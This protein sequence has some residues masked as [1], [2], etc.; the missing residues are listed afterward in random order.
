MAN[1]GTGLKQLWAGLLRSC[2]VLH[3]LINHM[4]VEAFHSF[5]RF[6]F[7]WYETKAQISS[8]RPM[9]TCSTQCQRSPSAPALVNYKKTIQY[10]T[11]Q[12]PLFLTF[13]SAVKTYEIRREESHIENR[14][15]T[16]WANIYWKLYIYFWPGMVMIIFIWFCFSIFCPGITLALTV[17]RYIAVCRPHQYRNIAS[18]S[19]IYTMLRK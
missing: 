4:R 16:L 17:E 9:F 19:M 7:I 18:V 1:S 6:L 12:L 2:N 5:Y 13:K 15:P 8:C 3:W 10:F 11:A 14:K